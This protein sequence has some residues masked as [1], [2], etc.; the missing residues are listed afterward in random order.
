MSSTESGAMV[1]VE[2]PLMSVAGRLRGV[3]GILVS[4]VV[5]S[6]GQ[7]KRPRSRARKLCYAGE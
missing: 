7:E 6:C 1:E 5:L 3:N 2:V 4:N